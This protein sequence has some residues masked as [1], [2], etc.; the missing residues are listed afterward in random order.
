M[1]IKPIKTFQELIQ[2]NVFS[3]TGSCFLVAAFWKLLFAYF[4][5]GSNSEDL[6]W[7]QYYSLITLLPLSA[8]IIFFIRKKSLLTGVK[9][10]FVF[11]YFVFVL[12]LYWNIYN[13]LLSLCTSLLF[14]LF[15]R[16]SDYVK[17]NILFLFLIFNSFFLIISRISWWQDLGMFVYTHPYALAIYFLSLALTFF[18]FFRKYS[19]EI[20][21]QN[22]F[23]VILRII[24]PLIIFFAA[25]MVC[26]Q[27]NP[28]QVH[29]WGCYT[30]PAELIRQGGYLLWSVPSQYGFLSILSIAFFPV[31]SCW[32]AFWILQMIFLVLASMMVFYILFSFNKTLLNYILSISITLCSVFLFPGWVPDLLGVSFFPSVGPFRFFWLY[33]IVFFI[34]IQY[35]RKFVKDQRHENYI[36]SSIWIIGCLWSFESAYYV[37]SVWLSYLFFSAFLNSENPKELIKAICRILIIP[38]LFFLSVV[39]MVCCFY[40]IRISEV[41]DIYSYA[42]HALS[43]KNGF[44]GIEINLKGGFGL[45]LL[46]LVFIVTDIGYIYITPGSNRKVIPFLIAL[47]AGAWAFISYFIGRSHENNISNLMPLIIFIA[48]CFLL[49]RKYDGVQL[50]ILFR[51]VTLLLYVMVITL[52]IGNF[53]GMKN[54]LVEIKTGNLN[55]K[56]KLPV[57]DDDVSTAMNLAGITPKDSIVYLD[58]TLLVPNARNEKYNYWL[59][60]NPE[61]IHVPLNEDRIKLYI[62]R[63]TKQFR[64]GG[65][66][67][68]RNGYYSNIESVL[69]CCFDPV[70]PAYQWKDISIQRYELKK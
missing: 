34:I 25:A 53:N 16:K 39:I 58:N 67:I 59:P 32:Q 50:N 10:F 40:W 68:A 31:E 27:M 60:V 56:S 1:S 49:I 66:L 5:P 8:A 62:R 36:G 46:L 7:L 65:Y 23:I 9:I 2:N 14:I 18:C 26:R 35:H 4:F 48:G 15:L 69:R 29:H 70:G 42:E 30:G 33:L 54:F 21:P 3:I 38:V 55:I 11:L 37:S 41:P 61:T 51:L 22:I 13:F 57:T 45:L 12:L 44:F 52:T 20:A 19:E 28:G 64:S 24:I 17:E 47:Y 6:D 43:F 63:F